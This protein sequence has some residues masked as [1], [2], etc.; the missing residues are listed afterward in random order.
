MNE[1]QPI[2]TVPKDGSVVLL[3]H[4]HD[5]LSGCSSDIR[6]KK[7]VAI[8]YFLDYWKVGVPGGHSSGGGDNQFTHWAP[9]PQPPI[10]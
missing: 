10:K 1:W 6:Q 9:L 3:L 7:M 4:A 8:G 2:K 5:S